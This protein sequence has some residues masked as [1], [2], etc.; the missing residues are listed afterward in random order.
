MP[1]T[2]ATDGQEM[3]WRKMSKRLDLLPAEQRLVV[4]LCEVLDARLAEIAEAIS[5]SHRAT[6]P[7]VVLSTK[8]AKRGKRKGDR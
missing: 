2:K 7:P 6:G 5:G 3:Q 8:E 4:A 1:G